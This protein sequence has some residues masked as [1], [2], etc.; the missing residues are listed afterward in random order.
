MIN[1]TSKTVAL[2]TLLTLL[3]FYISNTY[4]GGYLLGS[5]EDVG[6]EIK[7]PAGALYTWH[8]TAESPYAYRVLFP[9]IVK[10]S[11]HMVAGN[12]DNEAFFL[13]Y[14]GWS[15]VFMLSAVLSLFF[16]LKTLGFT[17]AWSFLGSVFFL[18]SPPVLLAYTLPVHTREDM[19]GYTL[20]CLGLLCLLRRSLLLF[21]LTAILGVLCRE[22]LLVLS[23]VFLF[24]SHD[25]K[26]PYRAA[27]ASVPVA[28]W[29][30]LRLSIDSPPYDLWEGLQWNLAN[31]EQVIGFSFITFHGMWVPL[32]YGILEKQGAGKSSQRVQLF[33]QSGLAIFILIVATTFVGGIFNEIRLLFL[34]FP[35][36]IAI[37]LHV[38]WRNRKLIVRTM[39]S[40]RY[41][42][43][44]LMCLLLCSAA[45]VY[46]LDQYQKFLEP[47]RYAIRFDVWIAATLFYVCVTMLALPAYISI[48][49]H[50]A[51][52]ADGYTKH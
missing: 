24:F 26:L 46:M 9:A 18:A 19:L 12:Q 34:L 32:F 27:I 45:G 23:F 15:L 3:I 14:Q 50:K 31:M 51:L 6:H 4:M 36:V 5:Y 30:A 22:T 38:F 52:F 43:Y 39:Q 41:K 33:Y 49:R 10:G 25:I 44:S 16:L 47:S 7:A 40:T 35:W 17:H 13:I 11:W 1:P 21:L 29:L 37:S 20:L 48:F 28:L 42:V 2:L 8:L